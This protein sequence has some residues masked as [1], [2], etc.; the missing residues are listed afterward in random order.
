MKNDSPDSLHRLPNSRLTR[1]TARICRLFWRRRVVGQDN[2]DSSKAS[3]FT[4]NHGR[5]AGP[6]TAVIYLPVRFRPWINAC[7]LDRE[8]AT[9]TMMKTFRNRFNF[10]GPKLKRGIIHWISGMV[11]HFL[12]SYEPIPVYKGM[13]K[14]AADTIALSADALA[15]GE[16]LLIFP[17]KPKD[18]YDEKSYK[19]FNT[20]FAALGKAYYDRTGQCLD[21]YPAWS[22]RETHT[23]RIGKPVTYDPA[24]DAR[25]EKQRITAE[26]LE[27][28]DALRRI[29]TELQP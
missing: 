13:P 9:D 3:V 20:G 19:D 10:L 11:C 4:C 15:R 27:R 18:R 22:D 24:G 26:L 29:E 5:T 23:F 7:M 2:I 1:F 6:V 12:N 21:F 8:E 17:E 14:A 28:M 16:N 25:A